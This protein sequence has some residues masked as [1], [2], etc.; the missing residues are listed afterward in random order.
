M[1]KFRTIVFALIISAF[2]AGAV[3]ATSLDEIYRDIVKDNNKGYLPLFVKNR[4]AP[5]F[6]EDDETLKAVKPVAPIKNDEQLRAV[7][8]ENERKKRE[9]A[10]KAAELKWQRTI[11]NIQAGKVT[12][13]ELEEVNTRMKNNDTHALE[14]YA[15]MLAR[16]VGIQQ[17]L[18]KS[19]AIYKQAAD[20]NIPNASKNAALVYKAMNR[21]QR[22][23]LAKAN[24]YNFQIRPE[25]PASAHN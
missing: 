7:N 21:Q 14:I 13:V 22:E 11:A 23:T 4:N 24:L 5:D 2:H 8:L 25:K 18:I 16:G 19:F 1:K 15:W 9:A 20:L 12:P 3:Q 6:L 17:D 10:Q